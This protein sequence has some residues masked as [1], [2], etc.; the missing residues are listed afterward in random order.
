MTDRDDASDGQPG[1]RGKMLGM[2]LSVVI[3]TYQRREK[4]GRVL[5][6]LAA[7]TRA[8]FEVI[9]VDDGS[10]D[11]TTEFLREAHFPFEL[12]VLRQSN[13]GPGAARNAGV[14]AARA[15]IVLFLD[16]D[17]LPAPGLIDEHLREHAEHPH[18]A[19]I[20]PLGS[21]PRY[22]LP[23]VA[24]EQAML[25]EQYAAMLRGDYQ[26]TFRQFWTGNASVP[27]TEL[28]AAGGFDAAFRRA[29]D[30]ELAARLHRRGIRFRFNP[31]AQTLHAAER[32]LDSWCAMH[33]A[34]GRLERRIFGH[35]GD[36]G[37]ISIL[38]E[39]WSRLHPATRSVVVR[40]LKSAGARR[41][42]ILGLRA[43]LQASRIAPGSRP[44]RAACSVLANV[45][46]WAGAR[47][48]M[49]PQG[50]AEVFGAGAA[51][52]VA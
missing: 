33:F 52:L 23:W 30:V 22:A 38:R 6:G 39:N 31:R 29:E 5:A 41:A 25:E 18:T 49:G 2:P 11:G 36:S 26:P 7:Q 13:A 8:G 24:W 12:R 46:Y 14:Q 40:T 9:V 15:D 27:R 16:D 43:L 21:L 20:G 28:L 50:L 42:V 35:F 51:G 1:P 44:A 3:A 19:V 4:L 45:L 48:A 17:V 34:Y 47:E 32:T 37:A 10:T